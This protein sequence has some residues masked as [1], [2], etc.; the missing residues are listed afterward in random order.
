MK[1]I[2]LQRVAN[3]GSLGDIVEVANG[4]ARNYLLPFGFAKRATDASLKEFEARRSEYEKNQTD[5]LAS[6]QVRQSK[7]E[8]QSFQVMAKA[9]VDGKLFGSVTSFDIVAAVNKTGVEIKKSEVTLPNGPLKT[10]GEFDIT[11][12]LHHD[13]KANI[14][15]NVTAEA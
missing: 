15:V 2:L 8:G 4:Y 10:I 13:V 9:G 3:L 5:I 14:K 12:I 7:L 11:V 6:A 1:I